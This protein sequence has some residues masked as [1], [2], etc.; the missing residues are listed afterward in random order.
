MR[1]DTDKLEG[2]FA[3]L[4]ICVFGT[5]ISLLV[6]PLGWN[7]A[8]M[9]WRVTVVVIGLLSI[10]GLYKTVRVLADETTDEVESDKKK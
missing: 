3:L 8:N 10:F 5:G 1:R 2:G 9:E 6:L 7:R 4:T